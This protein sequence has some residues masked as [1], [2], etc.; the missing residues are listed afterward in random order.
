MADVAIVIGHHPDAPG[1]VLGLAGRRVTEHALWSPFARELAYSL[2]GH[3][4]EAVVVRRPNANPDEAL[5][6]RIN[7]TRAKCAIE[8]H[9]N[10][11]AE[12]GAHGTEMLHWHR[13]VAG[14][15]L[16]ELLCDRAVHALRTRRRGLVPVQAGDRGHTFLQGTTMPAV[17][18]EPSFGTNTSD[19]WKLLTGQARL[20]TAY[21]HA[22][23]EWLSK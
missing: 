11:Y 1:A 10:A 12:E 20:M 9:F 6:K 15:D 19:A 22:L 4:I 18:C 13:S 7:A 21:R 17:I 14:R 2:Q 5:L 3:G 23:M 16:A 8:L